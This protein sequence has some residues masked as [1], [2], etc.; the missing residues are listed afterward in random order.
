M[1]A[2]VTCNH[3]AFFID[4]TEEKTKQRRVRGLGFR[5]QGSEL[6]AQASGLRV[7]ASGTRLEALGVRLTGPD[8]DTF[9]RYRILRS[10][11]WRILW[12]AR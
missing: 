5:A 4:N 12:D 1:V 2:K 10:K 9:L 11:V 6:R 3:E 8:A 7:L